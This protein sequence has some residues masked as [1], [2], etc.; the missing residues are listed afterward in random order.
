MRA[1]PDEGVCTIKSIQGCPFYSVGPNASFIDYGEFA[2]H[3]DP[4]VCQARASDY[5]NTCSKL[6]RQGDPQNVF[7]STLRLPSASAY[8][9]NGKH[10]QGCSVVVQNCVGM[11]M[12][13][14][15]ETMDRDEFDT[16]S[17]CRG[18]ARSYYNSCS[19]DGL[20]PRFAR[21]RFYDGA[22]QTDSVVGHGC[23]VKATFC[24]RMGFE[25]NGYKMDSDT[26]AQTQNGCMAR[27]RTW[28]ESCT[29]TLSA[30]DKAKVQTTS[31]FFNAGTELQRSTYVGP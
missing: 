23:V 22:A 13:Q 14:L 26:F 16:A 17:E 31:I 12:P 28:W 3:S 21:T 11:T 10:G 25:A 30:A 7:T 18:R 6:G 2:A 29:D 5:Y 24:P 19:A 9:F 4:A 1:T 27:S 15:V 8:F 20:R